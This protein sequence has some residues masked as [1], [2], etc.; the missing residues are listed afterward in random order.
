MQRNRMALL[1]RAVLGALSAAVFA[2]A[3]SCGGTDSGDSSNTPPP[4]CSDSCPAGRICSS[5][6]GCVE[7]L[8][9]LDCG[10][11]NP[12]CIDG[13]CE[14]CETSA[15]CAAGQTC[16]PGNHECNAACATNAD[17]SGDAQICNPT[18][19]ACVECL[20]KA[21]CPDDPFCDPTY[22][23][24]AE[25]LGNAD[26]GTAQPFCEPADGQCR[27]CL[28]DSHCG[29]HQKC[30]DKHCVIEKCT[31]DQECPGDFPKCIAAEGTC[32]EC[33]LDVDCTDGDK[34]HCSMVN[35][36]ERCTLNE[37]CAAGE[38]C[39]DFDCK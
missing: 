18:T 37:H 11:A 27:E 20:V 12:A 19:K 2:W 13:R 8:L 30:T 17:C 16:Y 25:C 1:S 7:C 10:A 39:V 22:G 38:T 21:D 35:Q 26:C 24:C 15:D 28:L 14:Q 29:I 34:I 32:V 9:D 4:S 5:S 36:C 33:L 3:V 6:L 23:K 31:V